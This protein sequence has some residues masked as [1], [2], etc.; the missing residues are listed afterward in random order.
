VDGA[1][2]AAAVAESAGIPSPLDRRKCVIL[3]PFATHIHPACDEGLRDLERRGY[4]VRRVGGYAAI[5]QGRSQMAT[6][7]LRAGFEETMWID[8]DI[9]F[10]PDSVDRLRSHALPLACGIYPQKAKR[11]LACHV[12]PGAPSMT[13]GAQGGL[14]ELLY[15]AAGFLLIRREVY[16]KVQE[17]CHLPV[18]NER[19]G[20]PLIPFF[21]PLACRTDNGY[22]YLAEDYAFCQRAHEAGF[23]IFADTTIRLWHLGTYPYGWEDAGIEPQRYANFTLNFGPPPEA[24]EA[25]K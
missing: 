20:N 6:D 23:R 3:V 22:W 10:H 18:C 19:F 17:Q 12:L 25:P 13:F 15:A 24:T 9:G 5:D 21:Q 2:C 14:F 11:A 4:S 16:E 7:A 1:G 8:A